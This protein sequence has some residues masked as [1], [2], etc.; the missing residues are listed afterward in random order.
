MTPHV[1]IDFLAKQMRPGADPEQAKLGHRKSPSTKN[2]FSRPE[3]YATNQMH[4][5]YLEAFGKKCC[6]FC[7]HSEVNFL[8]VFDD[9]L[10]FVIFV[11]FMQFL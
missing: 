1:C 8:C 9:F 4:S 6:Y 5:K 11:F 2:F 3:S 10:D 7:F